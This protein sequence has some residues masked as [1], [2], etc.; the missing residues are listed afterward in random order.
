VS[1]EPR[2][3]LEVDRIFAALAERDVDFVVIGG[4]AAILHGSPRITFDL[5][6][7][8]ATDPANLEAL[9][10][11][12]VGL[13][14][15]L[16]GAPAGLPFVPDAATLRGIEVLTLRTSAGDLDVLARPAGAPPYAKLR[17][18]ADR[19][20]IEGGVTILVASIEDL[21]AMKSSAR[22]PKDLADI[23]ELAAI[24]RLRQT[25]R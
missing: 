11:V 7:C 15:R 18:R 14:A 19:V 21:L 5:D 16:R 17:E 9:G 6:V 4:I 23:A 20:E 12:L 8:F 1:R 25:E 10:E 13:E 22:R 24:L 3:D 2:P